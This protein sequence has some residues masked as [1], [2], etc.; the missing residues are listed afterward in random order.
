[1]DANGRESG[2]SPDRPRK[3]A[4]QQATNND[5]ELVRSFMIGCA[6]LLVLFVIGSGI[7]TWFWLR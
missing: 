1:M 3:P 4:R 2:A 7:I 5:A 6:I